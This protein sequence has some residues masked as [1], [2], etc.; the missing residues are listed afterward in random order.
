MGACRQASS[1]AVS[2]LSGWACPQVPMSSTGIA[3]IRALASPRKAAAAAGRTDTAAGRQSPALRRS[4]AR[5]VQGPD[6]DLLS[7]IL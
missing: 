2:F 7:R 1:M 4:Q 5:A 6:P 3:R